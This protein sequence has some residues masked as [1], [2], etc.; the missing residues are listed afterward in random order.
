MKHCHAWKTWHVAVIILAPFLLVHHLWNPVYL[1]WETYIQ[2]DG[3]CTIMTRFDS[4]YSVTLSVLWQKLNESCFALVFFLY[5]V[6]ACFAMYIVAML[7]II[8][9]FPMR[10]SLLSRLRYYGFF[11]YADANE[12]GVSFKQIGHNSPFHSV[13]WNELNLVSL[14]SVNAYCSWISHDHLGCVCVRNPH[15]LKYCSTFGSEVHQNSGKSRFT[16]LTMFSVNL[17][18]IAATNWWSLSYFSNT[19]VF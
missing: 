13:I 8:I 9:S 14:S 5:Q 1:H 6:T 18:K 10:L 17:T 4:L 16:S 2:E 15:L 7:G 12:R 3:G 11:Y 19:L